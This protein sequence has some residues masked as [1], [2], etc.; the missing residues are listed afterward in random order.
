MAFQLRDRVRW[1]K[2]PGVWTVEVIRDSEPRYHIQ[3][4]T[5]FASREWAREDELELVSKPKEP[6]APPGLVPDRPLF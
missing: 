4:G 2:K 1:S 6:D 5:E 3:L